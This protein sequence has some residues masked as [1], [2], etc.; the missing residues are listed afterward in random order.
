MEYD[1]SKYKGRTWK[2]PMML[3]WIV[4][5]GLAF[6]ELV[7]GQRVPKVML[8]ERN[9]SKAC[10]KKHSFPFRIVAPYTPGKMVCRK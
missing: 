9:D 5:P 2:N 6:N 10:R 1:Q 3:H 7:L 8:I 4:N